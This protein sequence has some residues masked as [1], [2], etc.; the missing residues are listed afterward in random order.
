[1][2]REPAQWREPQ[3]TITFKV[4]VLNA[5]TGERKLIKVAEYTPGKDPAPSGGMYFSD[6][7]CACP[8]HRGIEPSPT[9]RQLNR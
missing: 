8:Q 6:E 9:I 5:E 4:Y 1:M 7:P 2:T 3:G